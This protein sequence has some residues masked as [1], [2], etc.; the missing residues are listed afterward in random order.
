MLA[1]SASIKWQLKNLL[2]AEP[3][4]GKSEKVWRV[5]LSNLTT[6]K[7]PTFHLA[8]RSALAF[9]LL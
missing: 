5:L 8:H 6:G 3:L 9:L 4:S 1:S 2:L 7:P